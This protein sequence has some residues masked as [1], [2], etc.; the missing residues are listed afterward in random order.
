MQKPEGI[1]T[2]TTPM[3]YSWDS[4]AEDGDSVAEHVA[5][6][7][8]DMPAKMIK[9]QMPEAGIS[10]K[11]LELPMATSMVHQSVQ[12]MAKNDTMA[13]PWQ[14]S[15][16]MRNATKKKHPAQ[17][18]CELGAVAPASSVVLKKSS[19]QSLQ[20]HTVFAEK[21]V[22]NSDRLLWFRIESAPLVDTD[23]DQDATLV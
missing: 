15:T 18:T 2:D 14:K 5:R 8:P 7:G 4:V 10:E 21:D 23:D 9:R 11:S 16:K 20:E 12:G 3:P 22:V 1:H 13:V 6:P 17:N 19:Y